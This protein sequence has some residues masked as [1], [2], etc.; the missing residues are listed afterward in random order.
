M[1]TSDIIK[2]MDGMG[3][4]PGLLIRAPDYVS[5]GAEIIYSTSYFEGKAVRGTY[6]GQKLFETPWYAA[7]TFNNI[8]IPMVYIEGDTA[9]TLTG[10]SASTQTDKVKITI[11]KRLPGTQN[12]TATPIYV[13][14]H[15][16]VSNKIGQAP[17]CEHWFRPAWNPTWF[18]I[19]YEY[20]FLV[21]VWSITAGAALDVEGIYLQY[22]TVNGVTTGRQLKFGSYG[23]TTLAQGIPVICGAYWTATTD[24]AGNLSIAIPSEYFPYSAGWTLSENATGSAPS[25]TGNGIRGVFNA[26]DSVQTTHVSGTDIDAEWMMANYEVVDGSNGGYT[27]YFLMHSDNPSVQCL[28]YSQIFGYCGSMVV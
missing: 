3:S 21:E 2:S 15:S 7:G 18:D 6:K 23:E 25:S 1:A 24:G 27:I 12:I 17:H 14:Y 22:Y 11:Y 19:R 10:T 4:N 16:N 13:S 26:V 8:V 9:T 20:K 5:P 28:F